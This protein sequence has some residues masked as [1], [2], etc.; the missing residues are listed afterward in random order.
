MQS[1]NALAFS[2][3]GMTGEIAVITAFQSLNAFFLTPS[4]PPLISFPMSANNDLQNCCGNGG[5]WRRGK[6][7]PLSITVQPV[8]ALRQQSKGD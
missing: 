3:Q 7:V 5:G 2:C 1:D 8:R 4:T 6:P